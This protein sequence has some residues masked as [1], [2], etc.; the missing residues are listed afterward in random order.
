MITSKLETEALQLKGA[1]II[2]PLRF[3]DER[4]IFFKLYT[5]EI[6]ARFNVKPFFN[7]EYLSISKKN[8]LRGLHFQKGEFSQ[9]KLVRCIRGEV[10]DVI[11]DLRK[12]SPTFSRWQGIKLSEENGVCLYVPRGFAH[13][14]LAL[15]DDSYVMYKADNDYKPE[16]EDGII[17]NDPNLRIDWGI[18]N[19]ILSDKDKTWK[20]IKEIEPFE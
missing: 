20:T 8:V 7:E 16:S 18:A 14:F 19:P 15:K 9:A 17:W 11:V 1:F 12:S 5:K 10:Y 3:D 2:R 4:G 13:G 6:L